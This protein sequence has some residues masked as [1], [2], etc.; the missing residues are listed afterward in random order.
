M[1]C[2]AAALTA[3]SPRDLYQAGGMEVASKNE[4]ASWIKVYDWIR[5]TDYIKSSP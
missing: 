3:I 5:E 4:K 2:A 1:V